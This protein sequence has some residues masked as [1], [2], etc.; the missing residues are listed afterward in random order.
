MALLSIVVMTSFMFM[1]TGKR[2]KEFTDLWNRF[3]NANRKDMIQDMTDILEDI[4]ARALKQKSSLDYFRAC[5]EYVNVKSR[6]NWKLTSQLVASATAELHDY[7]EPMLEILFGLRHGE[8]EVSLIDKV[9]R[10][11]GQMKTVRNADI[12][13]FY[14]PYVFNLNDADKFNRLMIRSIDNDYEFILWCLLIGRGYDDGEVYDGF[15]EYLDDSY[16]AGPY[17]DWLKL[18][19]EYDDDVRK[20]GLEKLAREYAG[21]GIGVAAEDELLWMKFRDMDDDSSSERY[22]ELEK[23][24]AA[25]EARKRMLKGDEA[26]VAEISERSSDILETLGRKEAVIKIENGDAQVAVRNMDKVRFVILKGEDAVFETVA[27]NGRKSFYRR[28]TLDVDI[29]VLDDGKYMAVAYDGAKE[30]GRYEYEKFTVSLATRQ[31]EDGMCIYAAD[32]L[33]GEPVAKADLLLY[34]SRMEKVAE[35]RDFEFDGFTA[36]PAKIYPFRDRNSYRLVCTYEKDGLVHS[37]KPVYVNNRELVHSESDP[38]LWAKVVKDRAAFVPGDTVR[39]KVFMYEERPDGSKAS[40]PEGEDVDIE[41]EEPS[42]KIISRMKLKTNGFGTASGSFVIDRNGR[43]GMWRIWVRNTGYAAEPSSFRVDEFVL[44]SYDLTFN[45]ADKLYFPGDEVS[46]TGKVMSYSGHGLGGL[47]ASALIYVNHEFVEEKLVS[48]ASDGSFS[49]SVAAGDKGDDYVS[50]RVEVRL[51]DNTGETSE[52]SWSSEAAREIHIRS[53]LLNH[54]SGSFAVRTAEG[55]SIRGAA[56]DNMILSAEAAEFKCWVSV[57]GGEMPGIP[58]SYEL[59]YGKDV[60]RSGSLMSGDTLK[61]DMRGLSS[62]LYEFGL[63]ASV[64]APDGM[65]VTASEVSDI[66]YMPEDENVVSC[67]VDRMFRTS[68]Q[69]GEITMQLGSGNGP[70]WAVVELF[71]KNYVPLKRMMVHLEGKVGEPGSLVTLTFP[72]LSRYSDKVSLGVF[73]FKDAGSVQFRET[74]VRPKMEKRMPLEFSSFVDSALPGQEISMKMKTSPDAEVLVSVF[75]ASSQKIAFNNWDMLRFGAPDYPVAVSY[76]STAG[77]DATDR[78]FYAAGYGSRRKYSMTGRKAVTMNAMANDSVAEEEAVPFQM[79]EVKGSFMDV[80]IRDDFASTLAFE[81]FLRPSSDGTVEMRFRTSGKLSTFIVKAMAHD[82]SM[83]TAFEDREMV[84]TLPV[85]VSVVQPQYLYAGDKYVLN[86]SV[87]NVS[88]TALKGR[89]CLEVFDGEN[90][91]GVEPAMVES[92]EVDVPA[93]GSSALSFEVPVP[94]DVDSLGFKVVFEGYEYS[95]SM[96]VNDALVSDGMFVAVPVHPAA[97]ILTESHSAV[98][99]GGGSADELLEKLRKE[100]VNVSSV[101][102]E[103]SEVSVMDMIRDALPVAYETEKKDAVSLSESM[104]INFMAADLHSG[105]SVVVRKCVGAAMSSVSRLLACVNEDGGFGWFEGMPSS[106]LVTALV[107]ERYAGLSDRRLLDVAQLVWGEDSL[108]ELD[109]AVMEAVKY[110][111]SSYFGEPERPF[112]YGRLSLG[113]YLTVRSKFAGVGFDEAAARKVA[114]RK[115]YREFQKEVR[116]FLIPKETVTSGDVLAKVRAVRIIIDLL[117]GS[118][119]GHRLSDAWGLASAADVRKMVKCRDRELKSLKQYAVEHPSGGM[120]YPNAVMP[121][122]GLLE[123]E[124]YA[125]ARICSLFKDVADSYYGDRSLDKIADGVRI[126]LMLQKETQEWDSDPGF[127]EALAA[128]YD[129]SDAVKGTMVLVLKKRYSK[130]FDEIKAAGNGFRVDVAY[131]KAGPDGGRVRLSYGDLLRV[132]DK[133]TA[134]YSLWSEENRSHVR[135]SVPRAACFRPV[136]QLSG[137][138]GGWFRPLLHGFFRV[139][140]YSYREVKA[141]RTLWWIDVFPEEDTTIEEEL[142]VT[143]EGVFSAPVAEIESVYAPHYRANDSWSNILEISK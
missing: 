29:P 17:V 101:G 122:R 126:W 95:L 13:K 58:M 108:D 82:K 130:P 98:L 14:A 103:Y 45:E 128:V 133:V 137:W 30:M 47:K 117:D 43:N 124:A 51:V 123:S 39:F 121:W 127:V 52:F 61:L 36:L 109:S 141:D 20:A 107:L 85:R 100:F 142:F 32:Y 129:G 67:G 79:V 131:Y 21:R 80:S 16:P 113:Q 25:F 60:V 4:K 99:L 54:D 33:S 37:S 119:A 15:V 12:Y 135:L 38:V 88:G 139:S 22:R 70:V 9:K 75:D 143:Q 40:V 53:R 81:P 55:V 63:S 6:R 114:G 42:G 132:G 23:D 19:R 136:E 59:R 104:F 5:D 62:G 111:D 57:R 56:V 44:P 120:Y 86:A 66:L 34:D 49:V 31:A 106:P 77:C 90:Y 11:A 26:A 8:P 50:Y 92:V 118:L 35:Y 41:I 84:V 48:I 102:A 1:G 110:L 89:L 65:D 115:K 96:P 10:D 7:G 69:D 83:N 76:S 97:Q 91:V 112:W 27:V 93:G 72:H 2:D 73:Y 28:D 3:Y 46:V 87:S 64:K 68:Y 94:S 138:S 71:G 18:S 105:D 134:V 74:F 125:H 140:P 24:V 116:T 78:H